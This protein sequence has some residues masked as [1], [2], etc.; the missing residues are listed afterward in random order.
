MIG[1]H[2]SQVEINKQHDLILAGLL[3]L[4]DVCCDDSISLFSQPG[5]ALHLKTNVKPSF[6]LQNLK[7]DAYKLKCHNSV[8]Y[9]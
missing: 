4:P 6:S 2:V 3:L 9:L 1:V 8:M 7:K 5:V